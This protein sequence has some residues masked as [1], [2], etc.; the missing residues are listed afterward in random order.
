M[1]HSR[2]NEKN[3]K[4]ISTNQPA[5]PNKADFVVQYEGKTDRDRMVSNFVEKGKAL[6]TAMKEK[7]EVLCVAQP[8]R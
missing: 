7:W 8:I 4:C 3:Y 5:L 2:R 1:V 6:V